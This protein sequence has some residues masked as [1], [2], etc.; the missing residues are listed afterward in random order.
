MSP[1]SV[2]YHVTIILTMPFLFLCHDYSTISLQDASA[3]LAI[4]TAECDQARATLTENDIALTQNDVV[5]TQVRSEN[6]R[7]LTEINQAHTKITGLDAEIEHNSRCID[8]QEQEISSNRGRLEEALSDLRDLTLVE[9]ELRR[10]F[11]ALSDS[12]TVQKEELDTSRG[13]VQ[14][15]TQK[16]TEISRDLVTLQTAHE[17]HQADIT[18][19][20]ERETQQQLEIDEAKRVNGA[21]CLYVCMHYTCI[22]HI[23]TDMHKSITHSFIH[24]SMH[25]S[26]IPN[27][28]I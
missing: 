14:R 9:G 11:D 4:Q 18:Q 6:Q 20:G 21:Y 23:Y 28:H 1:F 3:A 19:A 27:S 26:F 13:T 2:P 17:T 7:L 10:A 5:L 15:L 16:V 12:E 25:R 22:S 8:E 24:S